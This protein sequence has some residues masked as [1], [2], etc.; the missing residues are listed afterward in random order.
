MA[1]PEQLRRLV[2]QHG[3]ALVREAAPIVEKALKGAAPVG[4]GPGA[5][6]TRDSVTVVPTAATGPVLAA[7]AR[8]G[9]DQANY[10]NDGTVPHV[11]VPRR[12]KVLAFESGGK[13]RFARRV[14]HPG[15]AATHWW[16]KAVA[17][18]WADALRLARGRIRTRG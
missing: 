13:M 11:I 1:D 9:T 14:N 16:D 2:R 5:G 10:T 4:Q 3:A 18:S 12:A 15:N 17:A 6:E 8:V 7:V